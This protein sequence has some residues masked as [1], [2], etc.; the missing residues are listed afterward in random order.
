MRRYHCTRCKKGIDLAFEFAEVISQGQQVSY[1]LESL[2][3]LEVDRFVGQFHGKGLQ[4]V[5]GSD[6]RHHLGELETGD[7]RPADQ[8][9]E[10][11]VMRGVDAISTLTIRF[12]DQPH[13]FVKSN[14]FR[15]AAGEPGESSNEHQQSFS[16]RESLSKIRSHPIAAR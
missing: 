8:A 6:E 13:L 5:L 14:G 9:H 7:L 12:R 3:A 10:R 1:F 11:E 15:G 16:P 2:L 4:C